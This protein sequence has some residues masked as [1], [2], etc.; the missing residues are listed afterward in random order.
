MAEAVRAAERGSSLLRVILVL[1][2]TGPQEAL[3]DIKHSPDSSLLAVATL[4]T[5]FIWSGEQVRLRYASASVLTP[6]STRLFS[7]SL[8]DLPSQKA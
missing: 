6:V 8:L 1:V 5:L 3:Q 4:S 2:L 7:G